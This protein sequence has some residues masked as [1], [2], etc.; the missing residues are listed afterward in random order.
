MRRLISLFVVLTLFIPTVHAKTRLKR[1]TTAT[2]RKNTFRTKSFSFNMHRQSMVASRKLDLRA[3]KLTYKFGARKTNRGVG[4]KMNIYAE[5][6]LKYSERLN[7]IDLWIKLPQSQST[8][9]LIRQL[10]MALLSSSHG[11]VHRVGLDNYFL[12][13]GLDKTIEVKIENSSCSITIDL[14]QPSQ[15]NTFSSI[16]FTQMN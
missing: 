1:R 3:S 16:M 13:I 12:S 7:S 9:A 10:D 4:P 14:C 2:A 11:D 5:G 6:K 15:R 8:N